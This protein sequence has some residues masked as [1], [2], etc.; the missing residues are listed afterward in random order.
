MKQLLQGRACRAQ[1]EA[2]AIGLLFKYFS[3]ISL[4]RKRRATHGCELSEPVDPNREMS[5]ADFMLFAQQVDILP[6][7]LSRE[8]IEDII[9]DT[10]EGREMQFGPI[11]FA[12]VKPVFQVL[13][14]R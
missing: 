13:F 5:T 10:C 7:L 11:F 4:G 1:L 9:A 6:S 14:F 12:S 2:P 3:S 8:C